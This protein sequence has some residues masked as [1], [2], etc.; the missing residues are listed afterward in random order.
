MTERDYWVAK[1]THIP[2]PF[3]LAYSPIEAVEGRHSPPT[4]QSQGDC[5]EAA[6]STTEPLNQSLQLLILVLCGIN[7]ATFILASVLSHTGNLY[8]QVSTHISWLDKA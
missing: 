3:S 1:P 2:R 4:R 6:M 5:R 7:R 8:L